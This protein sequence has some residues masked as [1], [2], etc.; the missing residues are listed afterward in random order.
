M[1]V[2][3]R[4][5]TEPK[6]SPQFSLWGQTLLPS[7]QVSQITLFPSLPGAATFPLPLGQRLPDPRGQLSAPPPPTTHR[8]TS[9][10]SGGPT[11]PDNRQENLEGGKKGSN[12]SLSPNTDLRNRQEGVS[13]NI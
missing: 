3:G 11:F 9:S 8:S 4:E 6:S 2:L 1:C 10:P 12:Q 5:G 7:T 13:Q